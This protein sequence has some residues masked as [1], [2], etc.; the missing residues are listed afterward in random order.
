MR[1]LFT[2]FL[3]LLALSSVA[4]LAEYSDF[5]NF[6]MN[7]AMADPSHAVEA[8]ILYGSDFV[9]FE[10]SPSYITAAANYWINQRHNVGL[11]WNRYQSGG[12]TNQKLRGSY[13]VLFNAGQVLIKPVVGVSYQNRLI[14][15]TMP[16]GG[17]FRVGF[18]TLSAGAGVQYKALN[19]GIYW[20]EGW[21]YNTLKFPAP[22]S[23][24]AFLANIEYEWDI[25]SNF[26]LSPFGRLIRDMGLVSAW[27]AWSYGGGLKVRLQEIVELSASYIQNPVDNGFQLR[28]GVGFMLLENCWLRYQYFLDGE[29][30]DLPNGHAPAHNFGLSF[31]LPAASGEE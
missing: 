21:E 2:P 3:L 14:N 31:D 12:H 24:P 11:S 7:P 18:M 23:R 5:D 30:Y 20:R 28:G 16:P 8:D 1:T 4:Q 29:T 19:G 17:L 15:M 6:F 9:R 27:R 22:F 13:M 10:G 25:H 26:T